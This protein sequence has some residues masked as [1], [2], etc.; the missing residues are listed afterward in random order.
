MTV[1]VHQERPDLLV[2]RFR[3][4]MKK[5]EFEA[6]QD[7]NEERIKQGDGLTLLCLF[8]DFEGWDS[9]DWADPKI[10]E[11][12]FRHEDDVARIALVC[13]DEAWKD[14]LLTFAGGGFTSRDVRWFRTEDEARA[15]IP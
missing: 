10:H 11:F 1:E 13:A 14:P 15:W 8:E 12:T 5:R 7:D 3:G 9:G 4:Q 6:I 2:I